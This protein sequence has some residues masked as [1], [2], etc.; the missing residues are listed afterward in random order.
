VGMR[1][2]VARASSCYCHLFSSARQGDRL[3]TKFLKKKS[4]H[5]I[6][7]VPVAL[8]KDCS[9]SVLLLLRVFFF[10]MDIKHAVF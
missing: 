5:S 3:P 8:K 9:V 6:F 2:G 10:E 7:T 4:N 1:D